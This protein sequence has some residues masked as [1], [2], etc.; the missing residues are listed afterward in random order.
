M[1]LVCVILVAK[2]L[3]NLA[4]EVEVAVAGGLVSVLATIIPSIVTLTMLLVVLRASLTSF[5]L[6]CLQ[7]QALDRR[8]RF[9]T[10]A[11]HQVFVPKLESPASLVVH[12]DE[13][14]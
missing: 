3:V 2:T 7:G 6:V 14:D 12:V 5:A 9:F 8:K 1:V 13:K 10:A 4:N 11:Y